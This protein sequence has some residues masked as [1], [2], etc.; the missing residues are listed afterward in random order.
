MYSSFNIL[1][2]VQELAARR[3]RGG[4]GGGGGGGGDIIHL[5]VSHR[6]LCNLNL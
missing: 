4:G 5:G 2:Y 1:I 6:Q 3:E